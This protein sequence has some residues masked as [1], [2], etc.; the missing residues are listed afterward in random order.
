[1]SRRHDIQHN[2][3][4]NNYTRYYNNLNTTFSLMTLNIMVV[5]LCGVSFMLNVIYTECHH[6]ECHYAE[7]CGAFVTSKYY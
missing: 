3:T 2:D 4:Q 5:L 7:C 1:M 6:A